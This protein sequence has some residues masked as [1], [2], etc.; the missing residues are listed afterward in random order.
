MSQPANL[1]GTIPETVT[2]E[3]VIS[4]PTA[5]DHY[6]EAVEGLSKNG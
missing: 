5:H 1:N 3:M 4:P 2:M 6:A